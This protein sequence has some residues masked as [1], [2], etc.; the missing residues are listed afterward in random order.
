MSGANLRARLAEIQQQISSLQAQMALLRSEE[1]VVARDLAALVYPVLTL[2]NDV[3][4]E[5]FIQYV[6]GN[7]F[8]KSTPRASFESFDSKRNH[9]LVD[10]LTFWMAH[11]GSLPFELAASLPLGP[12]KD[13]EALFRLMSQYSS[14]FRQLS[15]SARGPHPPPIAL[16]GPFPRLEKLNIYASGGH[17]TPFPQLEAPKLRDLLGDPIM[18]TQFADFHHA[19]YNAGSMPIPPSSSITL[20]RLRTVSLDP[21]DRGITS[22]II[23]Y[24]TLPALDDFAFWP[25]SDSVTDFFADLVERSGCPLRQLTL[26]L[27]QTDAEELQTFL[28]E[29]PLDSIQDLNLLRPDGYMG[30]LSNL[31]NLL[32]DHSY[33]PGLQHLCIEDCAAYAELSPVVDMLDARLDC[34]E[35]ET[36]L[37]SFK[38]SFAEWG[39]GNEEREIP[40]QPD[41]DE[42]ISR[43]EALRRR[44]AGLKFDVRSEISWFSGHIDSH[45]NYAVHSY[46]RSSRGSYRLTL[47]RRACV[48]QVMGPEN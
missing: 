18:Y 32:G 11:S 39:T 13:G 9:H 4:S 38:L 16:A 46:L 31:F 35:G 45:M 15:L 33:L 25:S 14:R 24:L 42:A 3:V 43:L 34:E 30:A 22:E 21:L 17:S 47:D 28:E 23:P 20:P 6:N 40:Y 44:F 10:T 48:S 37:K 8:P 36:Q 19:R 41:V 27:Y 5:I 2:P 29:A 12:W 1:E 7:V 26:M